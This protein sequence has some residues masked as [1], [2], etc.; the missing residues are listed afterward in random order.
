MRISALRR[1]DGVLRPLDRLGHRLGLDRDV[2]GQGAPHD[3]AHGP[4][5]EEAQQL[6]VEAQ[7]EAALP[8]IALAARAA[9]QLVVDAT[10]LVALAAQHV[11][12]AE[13]AHLLA[14]GPAAR[15]DGGLPPLQLGRALVAVEVDAL[16]R[17]LVLGQQ[18]G[19]AAQDD[20]D[21]A[22]GHVGGDGHR[23]APAGLGHDLGLPEVLLGVEDVVRDA[24][25]VQQTRQQLGLGHR[26]GADQHGLSQLVAFDDV[27]DDR[28]ELGL[29]RLEDE[30][31]LVDP[32]HVHVG[33]DGHHGQAV[34]GG[35]L[36]GLG[37]GR[38]GHAGQLLVHAEVVLQRHRGPGVVLL[39]DGHA[40]LRLDRLVET[41]GP[42]PAF[43]RAPGELVDDLHLPVGDEVVL[44][45]VVEIL[46]RQG[47]GQLVD[48]I[49]GDG[50]VDVVDPDRLLHLLD[51]GLEGNDGLL[52]LVDL[53]V[54]VAG[55]GPGDGGELV[56]ELGRLVGRPRD[57]ER[58]ARLVDQDG[59][60][61][62]DD[63]E[64]VAPLGHEITG[65]RH[66]VAQ[67][68][69][70]ELVVGAVGDVRRVGGPLEGGVVDV[71]TDA[72]DREPEPAVDATHPLRVAGGQVLVDRHHVHAPPVEGVEVRRERGDEGLAL[73]GLHFGD[74]AEVQRHAAHELDVE[75]ALAEH[76]P[77]RLAHHGVRLDQEVVEASRPARAAP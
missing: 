14:L 62:V 71:R 75:V 48:V 53:V 27:L 13:L 50:V 20:V 17:Q 64:D 32:D 76:A 45:P 36:A 29:L 63:G 5:G 66:V 25:L 28:V 70:A 22:A 65:P 47:L 39:L 43:E 68:V 23:A 42:P 55:E 46:G 60:D 10:A 74:P 7:V 8:R 12:P 54:L 57:D 58:R 73:A 31:G 30:V 67:V 44:V 9:A 26:G 56:V 77:G 6:V 3:P 24:P 11:E 18:L 38:A 2:L 16:G 21:A 4:G 34:G 1:L 33:R 37:L 15:L 41:V 40:L 72:P 49:D 51:P 35:E 19:V 69:E 61:L 59:V 52:L